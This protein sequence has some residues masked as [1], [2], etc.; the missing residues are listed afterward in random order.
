MLQKRKMKNYEP[1]V[2]LFGWFKPVVLCASCGGIVLSKAVG[3]RSVE[4]VR[5]HHVL[6]LGCLKF[7]GHVVSPVC[8][9]FVDIV[10][11]YVA[12]R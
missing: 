10:R 1:F 11:T 4:G 8:R 5:G 7:K 6:S 2:E 3:F 12:A 9:N